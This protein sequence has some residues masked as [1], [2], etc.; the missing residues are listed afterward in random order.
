MPGGTPAQP[1][2]WRQAMFA[3]PAGPDRVRCTLCPFRCVLADGQAGVCKVR[4]NHRGTLQTATYTTAVTHLTA[5]E[6]KPLYHVRPGASVLTVAGPGCSFRCDYCINYR[7]SQYGREEDDVA[8]WTGEA[9]HP[10]E[11]AARAARDGALLGMSYSEPSLAPELTLALADHGIPV[12]WKSNGYLTAEALDVVA[13]ALLAVYIDIKA[14]DEAAHRHLTGASLAA[15]WAA[16]ERF[17]ASGVWVEVSTPLIPG[18]SAE[19]EKLA[20]IAAHIAS[21]DSNIPWHLLRFTPDFRMK[22]SAPTAPAALENAR[23]I[24]AAHG[25]RYVYVERALG[26]AGRNTVCPECGRTLIE[27][28]VWTMMQND[29]EDGRCPRCGLS[30]PGRW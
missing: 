26:P 20:A 12:I 29:I 4:R 30:I 19:Q 7:L 2:V 28:G 17:R 15:V 11:I 8:P 27:R 21:I 5:I 3:E 14:A 25:L 16:V 6:R 22:G 1:P 9:A 13:P 24:A 10:G 18:T 23:Q